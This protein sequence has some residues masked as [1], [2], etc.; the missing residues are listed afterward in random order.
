MERNVTHTTWHTV[1]QSLRAC[2]LVVEMAYCIGLFVGMILGLTAV[3]WMV[4]G[5]LEL[6]PGAQEGMRLPW[7]GQGWSLIA[8]YSAFVW[9]IYTLP[10]WPES[11]AQSQ[12]KLEKGQVQR[13]VWK[14]AAVW[15]GVFGPV[16][17]LAGWYADLSWQ[18]GILVCI[19]L[20]LGF[21]EEVW[22]VFARLQYD[23][24]TLRMI[25]KLRW[26]V[27]HRTH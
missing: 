24:E 7:D 5:W 12:V 18:M 16:A 25:A 14:H 1:Q 22:K 9:L 8:I 27:L 15:C 26:H 21:Y 6:L 13:A 11:L 20:A 17:F 19:V 2:L 4:A 23:S 3:V 10:G